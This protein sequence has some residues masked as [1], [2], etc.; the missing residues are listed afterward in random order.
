MES[1]TEQV[2]IT[3]VDEYTVK[4]M[5][6]AIVGNLIDKY[7]LYEENF[8]VTSFRYNM[9]KTYQGDKTYLVIELVKENE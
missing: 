2:D 7:D 3:G 5:Y 1:M 6:R 8:K 4:Y 9:D